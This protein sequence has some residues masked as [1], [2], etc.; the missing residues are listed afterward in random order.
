MTLEDRRLL[1]TIVVN[2]PTPMRVPGQTDLRQAIDQANT[3]G[4][5]S[6]PRPVRPGPGGRL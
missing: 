2:D 1:S 6:V 5:G 4:G 3:A